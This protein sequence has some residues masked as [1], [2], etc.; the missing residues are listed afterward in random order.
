FEGMP[1]A[2]QFLAVVAAMQHLS[3]AE[4]SGHVD[5]GLVAE[6]VLG[7]VQ[8]PP[9]PWRWTASASVAADSQ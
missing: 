5:V 1:G 9:R 2:L 6:D 3:G 7:L 4:G 8:C